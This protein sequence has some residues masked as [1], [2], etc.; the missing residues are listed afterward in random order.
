MSLE[1]KRTKT[2]DSKTKVKAKTVSIWAL[3]VGLMLQGML[4]YFLFMVVVFWAC[5]LGNGRTFPAWQTRLLDLSMLLV[6]GSCAG[7]AMWL[8]LRYFSDSPALAWWLHALPVGVLG[9]FALF[10]TYVDRSNRKHS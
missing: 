1:P 3:L 8:V 4:G 7:V 5:G 10:A 9:L 6:P 2:A